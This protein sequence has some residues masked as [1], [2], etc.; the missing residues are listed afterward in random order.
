M[1]QDLKQCPF[2]ASQDLKVMSWPT[3]TTADHHLEYAV[4]CMNCGAAGP[5]DL[6]PDLARHSWNMRRTQMP[7][8]MNCCFVLSPTRA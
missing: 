6:Y 1:S 3:T 2:C 8:P 7:I 4:A 5:N